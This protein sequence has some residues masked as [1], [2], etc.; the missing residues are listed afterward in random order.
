MTNSVSAINSELLSLLACPDCRSDIVPPLHC[1]G[2]GRDFPITEE[3]IPCLMPR[4]SRVLPAQYADPDYVAYHALT[5]KD[6]ADLYY[7]EKNWLFRS[8]HH[9]AH[10]TLDAWFRGRHRQG[11]AIDIGCGTGDHFL[12]ANDLK[13]IIGVDSSIGSLR[14]L[15]RKFPSACVVQGDAYTLPFRQSAFDAAFSIYNLEHL[16]FL[17]DA[18]KEVQ[19]ILLSDGSF[20]VG[21]PAEGGLAW[22]LGRKISTERMYK[23][24]Y[25]FDYGRVMQI[26]HCNTAKKVIDRCA[27][28]F[29]S[30]RR[31]FFPL[32]LL[33]LISCNLTISLEYHMSKAQGDNI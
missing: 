31:T 30:A 26:E 23:K 4:A 17:D 8:I 20:Y 9:S 19:R 2:C 24:R 21:L 32:P 1:S 12:Y 28:H 13:K 16:W 6:A 11:Y 10:R 29:S 25:G 33:P 14:V 27:A 3:G 7:S 22:T 18:L 5:E 15:L